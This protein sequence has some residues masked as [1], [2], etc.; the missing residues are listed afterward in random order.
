MNAAG[1]SVLAGRRALVTGGS[2]G[3]GACIARELARAGCTVGICARRT[4]LLDAVVEELRADGPEAVAFT[5]D[6]SDLDG[7]ESF[8]RQAEETLGGIDILVNNAGQMGALRLPADN[9]GDVQRLMLVNYFSPVRLTLALLPGM[10]DRGRGQI[11]NISSV[12]ARLSPPTESAYAASKAALTAY[13][14]AAAADLHLS[15]V[16][17]HN[18][19]PGWIRTSDDP[20][21]ALHRDMEGEAPET[22]AVAVRRQLEEGTFEIYVPDEFRE[23]YASRAQDVGGFVAYSATWAQERI[24]TAP[25]G[26]P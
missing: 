15:G 20:P 7:I 9:W 14:E 21:D 5:V 4:A 6:L 2:S 11:V 19:Y 8:A 23:L 24:D 26:T 3:I 10:L 12:A 16:S 22:V 18:V 1:G 25:A 17:V 13:F